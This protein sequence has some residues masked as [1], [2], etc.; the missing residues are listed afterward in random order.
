MLTFTAKSDNCSMNKVW[1]SDGNMN[2][3]YLSLLLLILIIFC[4]K[5]LPQKRP[6]KV[7]RAVMGKPAAAKRYPDYQINLK[8]ADGPKYFV[9]VISA[10]QEGQIQPSALGSL[11]ADLSGEG[12]ALNQPSNVFPKVIV[13]ADANVTILDIW[14][15]ITLFR[16][17]TEISVSIPTGM[18]SGEDVLV[19]VPWEVPVATFDV[20]PNPLR[21]VVSVAENGDLSLNNEPGGT[22]SNT[23]PLT[24]R[25]Q[26]IFKAR[27]VNGVFREGSNDIEKSVTIVMPVSSRKFSDLITVARAVWL[28]GCDRI[29]LSM[30]NPLGDFGSERKELLEVPL[31]PP[32]KKP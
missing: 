30:D 23:G 6:H 16:R 25:L 7:V 15:P 31:T 10:E 22:L 9:S 14:S 19:A 18:P 12:D 4:G 5:T 21:L 32:K 3:R 2:I 1:T 13:E 26:E 29:S 11:I 27:E 17:G 20:K 28:P 8:I 24:K